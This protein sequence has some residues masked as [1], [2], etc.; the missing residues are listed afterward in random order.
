M[1]PLINPTFNQIPAVIIRRPSPIPTKKPKDSQSTSTWMLS[2]VKEN[3]E[4]VVSHLYGDD[5]EE[6]SQATIYTSF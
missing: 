6:V 3:V 5:E 4:S 1:E 2:V